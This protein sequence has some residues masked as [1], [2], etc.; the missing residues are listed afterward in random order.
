MFSAL[1]AT[2]KIITKFVEQKPGKAKIKW[3]S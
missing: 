2:L 3:I 1:V